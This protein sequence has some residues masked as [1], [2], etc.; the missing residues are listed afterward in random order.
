MCINN[1]SVKRTVRTDTERPVEIEEYEQACTDSRVRASTE[2]NKHGSKARTGQES[3]Y[4]TGQQTGVTMSVR[5][6]QC[7]G[8]IVLFRSV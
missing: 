5:K 1:H 3:T 2:E 8:G 6:R 4:R 7:H